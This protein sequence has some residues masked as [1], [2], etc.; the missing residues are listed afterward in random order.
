MLSWQ[1]ILNSKQ[2]V[3]DTEV[4]L[5]NQ[6]EVLD[7]RIRHNY[8]SS[9]SKWKHRTETWKVGYIISERLWKSTFNFIEAV[10]S[11]GMKRET[12]CQIVRFITNLVSSALFHY[13]KKAKKEVLKHF[14][15]VVKIC[16]NREHIFFRISY[17]VH[18][19]QHWKQSLYGY[20]FR[21]LVYRTKDK[22]KTKTWGEINV[23]ES[24]WQNSSYT[25]N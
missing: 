22:N 4:K 21:H 17:G 19:R 14:K 11:Y 9:S 20:L 7:G 2:I 10:N 24:W 12:S 3:A 16:Q 18:G 25:T 6:R 8:V 15:H 5:T 1:N 23:S 13:K